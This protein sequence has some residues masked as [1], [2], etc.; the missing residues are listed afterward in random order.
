MSIFITLLAFEEGALINASKIA[1]LLASL[2]AGLAGFFW[3]KIILAPG[4]LQVAA[5]ETGF[6][7]NSKKL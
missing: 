6:N 5:P 2:V 1:I 4:S 3:L 7:G